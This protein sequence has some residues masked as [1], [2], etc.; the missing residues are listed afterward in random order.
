[1]SYAI[2]V[3]G[4]SKTFGN[5]KAV[6]NL[7]FKIPTGCIFGL[8][9]PNGSGKSTTIRM[10][11]GLMRPTAGRARVLGFDT[12]AEAEKVK[13][14]IGYMNQKFSLYEDLTVIENML[15]FWANLW[16]GRG[17]GP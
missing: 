11:C 10:L 3:E 1:M 14:N 9:G 4:L 7:S 17:R 15:F 12:V 5:L 8:L 6:E 16:P 13:E 2:E